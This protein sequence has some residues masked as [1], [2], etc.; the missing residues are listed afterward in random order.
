[1]N[2]AEVRN[3]L[4]TTLKSGTRTPGFLDLARVLAVRS[5]LESCASVVQVIGILEENR[6]LITRSFGVSDESF[7]SSV[8]KLKTLV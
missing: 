4:E 8:E 5:R 1:M 2:K 7:S 3:I 6:G